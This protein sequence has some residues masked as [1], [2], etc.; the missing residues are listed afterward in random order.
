MEHHDLNK[1]LETLNQLPVDLIAENI[2]AYY[3]T[4]VLQAS[5]ITD[6]WWHAK[7]NGQEGIDY[8]L[9]G[10]VRYPIF[11]NVMITKENKLAINPYWDA[12]SSGKVLGNPYMEQ[13]NGDLLTILPGYG[14]RSSVGFVITKDLQVMEMGYDR[15]EPS[16][17]V[18]GCFP[19]RFYLNSDKRAPL[20]QVTK[21]FAQ[22]YSNIEQAL[23]SK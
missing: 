21:T 4:L 6:E 11:E 20:V 15:I 2:Q 9:G 1:V 19:A 8:R 14:N 3:N 12:W 7:R 22:I 17:G 23:E 18:Q 5:K 13:T 16:S 10:I